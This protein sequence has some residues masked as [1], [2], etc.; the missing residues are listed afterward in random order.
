MKKDNIVIPKL[1]GARVLF[2]GPYPPPF[3]GIAQHIDTLIPDLVKADVD[4]IAVVSF[5][6]ENRTENI[7]GI[8]IYRF[9]IKL[10]IWRILSLLKFSLIAKVIKEFR[11]QG[12]SQYFIIREVIKAIIVD[13]VATK[14]K[15]NVVSSYMS[16]TSLTLL[17]LNKYWYGSKGILLTVYGEIFEDPEFFSKY[18]NIVN[19]L[20]LIPDYVISSSCHCANSFKQIGNNRPIEPVFIGVELDDFINKE[21]GNRFRESHGIQ[22]DKLLVFFMGRM[23]KDMGLDVVLDTA[24]ALLSSESMVHLLIAGASG[25]L[26]SRAY[27]LA[28]QYPERVMVFENISSQQK[29]E[30]YGAADIVT[31][32]SFNMRACM[33]ISIKE[34][35]AASLP[36]VAGAGGGIPEAVVDGVTG[37]LVPVNASGSVDEA[38]YL[39][40]LR[41]LINDSELRRHFGNAGRKRAEN[42]FSHNITN[43]RYA[44][45]IRASVKAHL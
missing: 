38:K 25:A 7:N 23:I 43:H 45:M 41:K 5:G 24:E 14:H 9:N 11:G 2:V 30:F 15:S 27:E 42:I 6:K 3:G 10:N 40:A 39:T 18:K 44:E 8:T 34:A 16:T 35:M 12:L 4:D 31:A 19:K 21:K 26:T 32:P 29:V 13:I 33:G 28:K 1:K 37:L 17:P 20:L 36:V 22:R